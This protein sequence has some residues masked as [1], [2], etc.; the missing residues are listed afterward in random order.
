M[1][2]V[3]KIAELRGT[4]SI[5][6]IDFW[7]QVCTVAGTRLSTDKVL[8]ALL[9]QG[10]NA[11][12]ITAEQLAKAQKCIE[13]EKRRRIVPK[14]T[15]T[16]ISKYFGGFRAT[17]IRKK[18]QKNASIYKNSTDL[19]R[20]EEEEF[21]KLVEEMSAIGFTRSSQVSKYIVTKKLGHKYKHISGLLEMEMDG[22]VWDFDGGFPKDIY[23]R[24]CKEMGLSNQGSDAVVRKFT[25]YKN[26]LTTNYKR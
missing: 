18:V 13:P 23:A 19:R 4:S 7:N 5:E 1:A 11:A 16:T 6:A 25:P 9:A 17:K 8:E 26:I 3:D 20:T 22:H 12:I 24:L 10:A 15:E 2:N 21:R 14:R